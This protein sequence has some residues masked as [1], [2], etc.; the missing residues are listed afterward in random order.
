MTIDIAKEHEIRRLHDVE[1]W[2]RGTIVSQLGVHADVVDRVLD[3]GASPAVYVPRPRLVDPYIGF[4]DE[5]LKAFPRLRATRLFDML[6]QRGYKAGSLFFVDT[7]PR[8]APCL[9]EKCTSAPSV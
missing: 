2:K 7:S 8:C 6:Q 1:K 5:T 3:A 4:I 9:V